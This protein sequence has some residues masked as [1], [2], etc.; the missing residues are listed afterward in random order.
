M[1]PT[2]IARGIW[3]P[4]KKC[5]DGGKLHQVGD[6]WE[7]QRQYEDGYVKERCRCL[8][9]GAIG[10][11][12]VWEPLRTLVILIIIISGKFKLYACSCVKCCLLKC[13]DP[14][15]NLKTATYVTL[16][17]DSILCLFYHQ[18][19][20]IYCFRFM[21]ENQK[22]AISNLRLS[23]CTIL[24][25]IKVPVRQYNYLLLLFPVLNSIFL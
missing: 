2:Q 9:G 8:A 3:K 18:L 5:S 25:K 7:I 17:E 12:P 6:T 13:P 21:T 19:G 23:A 4:R 11:G 10:C 24:V 1:N 15:A 22:L 20:V 16:F 14:K